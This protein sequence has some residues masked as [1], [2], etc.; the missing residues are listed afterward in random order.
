[1]GR[2]ASEM[3]VS[4]PQNFLNPPPVPE[5]PTVIRTLGCALANSSATASV[6]GYSVLEPSILISTADHAGAAAVKIESPSA[7]VVPCLNPIHISPVPSC[8]PHF[9]T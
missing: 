2:D 6:M 3:S 5:I 1:M 4:P 9:T 7:H 8:A